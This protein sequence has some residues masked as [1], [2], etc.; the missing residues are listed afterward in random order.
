MVS[1]RTQ[2]CEYSYFNKIRFY[3]AFSVIKATV[4]VKIKYAEHCYQRIHSYEHI[5]VDKSAA[6]SPHHAQEQ[7][8]Y[9]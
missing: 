3:R 9:L 2:E 7:P 1:E 6:E 8:E 5:Q 4:I